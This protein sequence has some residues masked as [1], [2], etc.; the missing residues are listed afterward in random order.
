MIHGGAIAAIAIA[1]AVVRVVVWCSCSCCR[2]S[3]MVVRMMVMVL[4]LVV[5][6]HDGQCCSLYVFELTKAWMVS[7]V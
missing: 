7:L 2:L 3:K 6:H 4:S 1:A 5:G